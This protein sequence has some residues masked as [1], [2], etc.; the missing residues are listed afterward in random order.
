MNKTC[1]GAGLISLDILINGIECQRPISYYVGGTCGNVMMILSFMGW[2]SFPVARLDDSKQS[3]RLIADMKKNNVHTDFVSTNDGKTPVI[4]QRNIIDKFGNPTHKFE[5]KDSKGRMFLGYSPVTINQAKKVLETLDFVPT[6]FFFDRI[7]PANIKMARILKEKGSII[8]FEP[9][10]KVTTPHFMDCI[11][12]SD[13]VKFSNQR[14]TEI[15]FF[16][17]LKLP[18]VIQ[19]LGENGLRFKVYPNEWVQVPPIKNTNI[20]D[21]AGAGDWTSSAFINL[22][23][24]QNKKLNDLSECEIYN[25]LLNAQVFG[26]KSCSYEGARGMMIEEFNY[27]SLNDRISKNK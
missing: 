25:M 14:I 17:E 23:F 11:N 3:T 21:T 19:T 27:S 5:F 18:L 4:I 15:K 16:N 8:F 22:L 6:V 24:E 10:C 12:I 1:L 9:S 7:T 20:I 26:S 13:I 2:D